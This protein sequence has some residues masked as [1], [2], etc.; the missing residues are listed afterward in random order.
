MNWH[1]G[2]RIVAIVDHPD[3]CFKKGQEFVIQG[4]RK[5]PCRCGYILIDI[6][7]I[8]RKSFGYCLDCTGFYPKKDPTAWFWEKRF[9]PI[10]EWESFDIS[11]LT[12]LLTSW[13]LA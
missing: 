1:I 12:E 5:S 2:Q 3:G 11:E 4:L 13:R 9:A 10:D 8:T 6:G 7:K